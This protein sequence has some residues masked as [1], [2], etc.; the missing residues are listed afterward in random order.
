MLQKLIWL[1]L[2]QQSKNVLQSLLHEIRSFDSDD[3]VE[4]FKTTYWHVQ[5]QFLCAFSDT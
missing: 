2:H 3:A 4:P 5:T 1:A